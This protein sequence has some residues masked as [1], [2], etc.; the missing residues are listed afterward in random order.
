[1][2]DSS[3]T[4]SPESLLRW[5]GFVSGGAEDFVF[6]L[7]NRVAAGRENGQTDRVIAERLLADF[8]TGGGGVGDLL[9]KL[10]EAAQSVERD[11]L[12]RA[13]QNLARELGEDE[14]TRYFWHAI[15]HNSCGD[16]TSRHGRIKTLAEWRR[17][18]LPQQGTTVCGRRCKCTLIQV[19]RAR[20][21]FGAQDDDGLARMANEEVGRQSQ[22]VREIEA[23]RGSEYALSTYLQKVGQFGRRRRE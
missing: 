12:Q 7:G 13:Q 8:E 9:N 5:L 21:L 23:E 3:V 1:M 19:D 20:R 22:F 17:I 6:R 16:C 18:G 15:G 11:A 10:E 14:T 4:L 2:I